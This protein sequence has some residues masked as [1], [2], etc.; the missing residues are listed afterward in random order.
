MYLTHNYTTFFLSLTQLSLVFTMY[1]FITNYT[2]HG[3]ILTQLSDKYTIYSFNL[4]HL[5]LVA[6]FWHITGLHFFWLHFHTLNNKEHYLLNL[7]WHHTGTLLLLYFNIHLTEYIMRLLF[8]CIYHTCIQLQIHKYLCTSTYSYQYTLTINNNMQQYINQHSLL[9]STSV[10][11]IH[12][13]F[14]TYVY[15]FCFTYLYRLILFNH[16]T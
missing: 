6:S 7:Y 5:S 2:S 4:T 1:A 14:S 9:H 8:T 11:C 13:T 16:I 12:H 15:V 3:I 10:S